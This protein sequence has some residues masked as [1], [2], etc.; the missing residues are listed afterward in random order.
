MTSDAFFSTNEAHFDI[1]FIDGLHTYEQ[2][3]RD[4][5]NA[6]SKARKGGWIIL[7]DML[8]LKWKEQHVPIVTTGNWTGDVWKVA[9]ELLDT[10]SIE[11]NI[12]IVDHGV[13]VIKVLKESPTLVDRRPHLSDKQ[14]GYYFERLSDLPVIE[15]GEFREWIQIPGG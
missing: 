9:F 1:V 14:F 12:V 3:R 11:F 7:H 6:L 2:V 4:L 5:S 8:P 15:W 10:T 13:G